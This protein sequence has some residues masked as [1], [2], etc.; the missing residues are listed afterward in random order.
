MG[1][2]KFPV[3]RIFSNLNFQAR[4]LIPTGS[5]RVGKSRILKKK[6]FR[7]F[8]KK[9]FRKKNSQKNFRKIFFFQKKFKIF[10][11]LIVNNAA[12]IYTC[13]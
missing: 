5:D 1:Y 10:K 12:R 9:I 3:I 13:M 8:E 7:I 6:F 4:A 11:M 2:K